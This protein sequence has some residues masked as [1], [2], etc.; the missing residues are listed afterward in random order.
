MWKHKTGLKNFSK[1]SWKS[2]LHVYLCALFHFILWRIR[3]SK[4]E[5]I[6]KLTIFQRNTQLKKTWKISS[7]FPSNRLLKYNLSKST[8]CT[9]LVLFFIYPIGMLF[10]LLSDTITKTQDLLSKQF[11]LS[12]SKIHINVIKYSKRKQT[13]RQKICL[14][15]VYIIDRSMCV[16][17]ITF[18]CINTLDLD[19]HKIQKKKNFI[20][21]ICFE[22]KLK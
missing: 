19:V 7:N 10:C 11:F 21:I 4:I 13:E 8:F 2:S 3:T 1:I 18:I 6:F 16:E 5:T 17:T 14:Q 15:F 9:E 20:T 12:K 22:L